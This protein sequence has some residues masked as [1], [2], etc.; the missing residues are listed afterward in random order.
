MNES[1]Y[2]NTG[3]AAAATR[4]EERAAPRAGQPARAEQD[5]APAALPGGE[6]GGALVRGAHDAVDMIAAKV[7]SLL[8]G[9]GGSDKAL[10]EGVA[11]AVDMRD[12]WLST[13]RQ[14][15]REHPVAALA[16]AA[17]I[18]VVVVKLARSSSVPLET[19]GD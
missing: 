17:L 19:D 7:T 11:K 3:D 15:I 16:T 2:P 6:L 5:D 10:E 4:E 14:A 13:A 8:G 9:A 1:T 18:G 12:E